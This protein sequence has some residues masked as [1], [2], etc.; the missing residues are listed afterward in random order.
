MISEIKIL[1]LFI[2]SVMK[3]LH[4][5]WFLNYENLC[6]KIFRF[7]WWEAKES[8]EIPYF[9][10][11]KE[12]A[13]SEEITVKLDLGGEIVK[14]RLLLLNYQLKKRFFFILF[15]TAI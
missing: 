8:E 3:Y 11:K 5:L 9:S 4:T 6:L 14:V 2:C 7:L 10:W 12:S 15:G 13:E 1:F